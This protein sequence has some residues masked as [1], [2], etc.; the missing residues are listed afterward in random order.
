[1]ATET[2]RMSGRGV[3]AAQVGEQPNL[4]L[5]QVWWVQISSLGH[6]LTLRSHHLNHFS[7]GTAGEGR[8]LGRASSEGRAASCVHAKKN[9]A[10]K[11]H[12]H[13]EVLA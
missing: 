5:P 1:M 10:T 6:F 11:Q 4:A 2:F 8:V 13:S 12:V 3:L 9:T 7:T